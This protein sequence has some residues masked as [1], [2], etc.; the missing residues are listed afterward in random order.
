MLLSSFFKDKSAEAYKRKLVEAR[1][2]KDPFEAL[3][4]RTVSHEERNYILTFPL[5]R[6]GTYTGG[7]QFERLDDRYLP[8]K[9]MA[10]R[11]LGKLDPSNPT[12]GQFGIE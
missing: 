6:E 3:G 2:R 4:N 7:G 11:T 5:F 1:K 12:K 8:F 9:S 10:T